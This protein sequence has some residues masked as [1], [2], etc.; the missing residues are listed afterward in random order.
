MTRRSASYGEAADI[1][2]D[3]AVSLRAV[4]RSRRL[5]LRET[6]DQSGVSLNTLSR[7]ERGRE[8]GVTSA[9]R[10]LRWLDHDETGQ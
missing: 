6:A 9:V 5:D 2:A 10:V 7:I 3:L 1:L 4:R 8:C